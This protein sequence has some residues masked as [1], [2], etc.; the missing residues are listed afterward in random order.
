MTDR[1]YIMNPSVSKRAVNRQRWRE[2]IDAWKRSGQSQKA[3]CQHHQLG[4][5]S[6]HRWHRIFQAEAAG[7]VTEQP[8]ATNL[9]VVIEDDLRVEVSAGF[10][11]HLLRQVVEVLRAS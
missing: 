3:F 4:L 5:A 8:P 6:L 9:T 7:G 1:G 11:P 2:R 10:D